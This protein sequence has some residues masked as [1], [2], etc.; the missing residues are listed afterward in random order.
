M[1]L[2][3]YLAVIASKNTQIDAITG[4]ELRMDN[5][6]VNVST[7]AGVGASGLRTWEPAHTKEEAAELA[8]ATMNQYSCNTAIS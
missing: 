2:P 7:D 1:D 3:G 4:K 8:K 6:M 5:E